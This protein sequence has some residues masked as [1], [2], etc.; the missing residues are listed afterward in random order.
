MTIKHVN[1]KKSKSGKVYKKTNITKHQ[2]YNPIKQNKT[3]INKIKNLTDI[4]DDI[5]VVNIVVFGKNSSIRDVKHSEHVFVLHQT[6]LR[7]VIKT[8]DDTFTSYMSNERQ[9]E[10]FDTLNYVNIVD[11]KRRK[12]HV[13]DLKVKHGKN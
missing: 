12:Q 13:K 8:L 1:T 11:K 9:I 10:I 2:F 6:E 4:H 5:P 3:H 7:K